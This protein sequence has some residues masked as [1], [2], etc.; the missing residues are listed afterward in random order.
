MPTVEN[1]RI[2]ETPTE[3][4]AG[5]TGQGVRWVLGIGIVAVIVAFAVIYFIYFG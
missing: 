5:E 1:N 2:V 4:R 3:A